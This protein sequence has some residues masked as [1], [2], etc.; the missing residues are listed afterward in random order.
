MISHP[1]HLQYSPFM[2]RLQTG[3]FF[4]LFLSGVIDDG[5]RDR[6]R[7][8][9]IALFMVGVRLALANLCGDRVWDSGAVY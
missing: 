6:V 5:P 8:G 1:S 3:P 4:V 7:G 2:Q 9:G